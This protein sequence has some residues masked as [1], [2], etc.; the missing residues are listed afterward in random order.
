VTGAVTDVGRVRQR[1]DDGF[2]VDET[3]GLVAVADGMG[4]HRG[5]DVASATA[6]EA[7]RASVTSGHPVREA[8]E[9]ANLAVYEKAATD[10]ALYGMGTTLTAGTLVSGGTVL[11]GHVGDSRAYLWHD[12][13]LS[14]VTADHS[15]VA[16]LVRE[17][18]ITE[19]EAAVHPMRSVITRALGIDDTI[20]VDV[21]PVQLDRGDLLLLCSDGLTGMVHEEEIAAALR[22]EPDPARAAERLVDMANAAGGED[23]VTVIVVALG[24]GEP[25]AHHAGDRTATTTVD[26]DRSAEP[27]S[28]ADTADSP[29][30]RPRHRRHWGRGALWVIPVVIV[31]AIAV[32]AVA[33]YARKDYFVAIDR[34]TVT[35]FKGVPG[36][37]LVWDPTIQRRTAVAASDL[38]PA[39][40]ASVRSE[41]KFGSLGEANAYVARLRA[42][43]ADSAGTGGSG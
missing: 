11:I 25:V 13:K 1:N 20:D 31:L 24:D 41:P 29:A 30:P 42:G 39:E 10:P 19:E 37:V 23:N 33:W 14:R 18:R 35:V 22:R 27:E 8:I 26:G 43:S 36:G 16:E 6:L 7:L 15:H 2:L 40:L 3:I 5:G 12:G 28:R 9:A 34:G 4:G 32:A 38:R 21:Y 17:G